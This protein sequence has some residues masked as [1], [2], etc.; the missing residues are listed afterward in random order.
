MANEG[1]DLQ[2]IMHGYARVIYYEAE[3]ETAKP[4]F[5]W[6]I[7]EGGVAGAYSRMSRFGRLIDAW[8][9][10]AVGWWT[11]RQEFA[12]EGQGIYYMYQ[13]LRDQ[14]SFNG[15]S[16]NYNQKTSMQYTVSNLQNKYPDH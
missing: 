16:Y 3:P 2:S 15:S 13:E 12:M 1:L 9:N 7:W 6:Y 11:D 4:K 14:G 8:Q 10:L 5:M